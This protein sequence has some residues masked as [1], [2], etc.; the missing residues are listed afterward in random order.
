MQ[1]NQKA[2]KESFKDSYNGSIF[3]NSRTVT[4]SLGII[5]NDKGS[6]SLKELLQVLELIE[7]IGLSNTFYYDASIPK[8][9]RE[10]LEKAVEVLSSET[11]IKPKNIKAYEPDSAQ[12]RA[13]SKKAFQSSITSILDLVNDEEL[14]KETPLA[15]SGAFNETQVETF[16]DILSQRYTLDNSE[17]IQEFSLEIQDRENVTGRRF[18]L[19]LCSPEFDKEFFQFYKF[20]KTLPAAK[21]A[22]FYSKVINS[23]RSHL[24][25]IYAE[26]SHSAYQP[27]DYSKWAVSEQYSKQAWRKVSS[28][29][30]KGTSLQNILDQKEVENGFLGNPVIPPFAISSL[31]NADRA[32]NGIDLI[33]FALEE[34]KRKRFDT[35]RKTMWNA[36]FSDTEFKN[37]SSLVEEAEEDYRKH[38]SK[39]NKQDRSSKL[40]FGIDIPKIPMS[41]FLA[42]IGGAALAFALSAPFTLG[43]E[44]LAFRLGKNIYDSTGKRGFI[45]FYRDQ[46]ML[47]KSLDERLFIEKVESVFG[48]NFTF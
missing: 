26:D 41:E 25:N 15:V 7:C 39:L 43:I 14:L 9:Y 44:V 27:T 16:D 11:D 23:F 28:S 1:N 10:E 8:K 6:I 38:L 32:K 48:K 45:S 31:L 40:I 24:L 37:F 29:I 13:L 22:E 20:T 34:S 18:V 46:R 47:L 30:N 35:F 17:L 12:K 2:N 42:G 19:N 4:D 3:S 21:R 36:S 33:N 5:K